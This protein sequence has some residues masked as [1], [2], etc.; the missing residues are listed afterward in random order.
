MI[1]QKWELMKK[2]LP[3]REI[4][5]INDNQRKKLFKLAENDKDIVKAIMIKYGYEK[6]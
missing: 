6:H 5:L 1:V 2:F 4:G 3:G